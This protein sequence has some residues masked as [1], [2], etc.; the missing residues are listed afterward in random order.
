MPEYI[1]AVISK[2]GTGTTWTFSLERDLVMFVNNIEDD[3]GQAQVRLAQGLL[4]NQVWL[5]TQERRPQD[6]GI[7][8][9]TRASVA[10]KFASYL[11]CFSHSDTALIKANHYTRRPRKN[12][13]SAA[14][15]N[16]AVG[17]SISDMRGPVCYCIET[18]TL[19]T[20]HRAVRFALLTA[21]ICRVSLYRFTWHHWDS[22]T[23]LSERGN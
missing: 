8:A 16:Q 13:V 14:S 15:T 22:R 5:W 12:L 23:V 7:C 18:K 9:A 2:Y 6:P 10:S 11:H 20:R 17:L 19:R 3:T 1:N 4:T 21:L